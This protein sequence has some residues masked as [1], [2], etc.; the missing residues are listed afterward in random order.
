MNGYNSEQNLITP[1]L[2]QIGNSDWKYM[3]DDNFE[4]VRVYLDLA[5]ITD[6]QIYT[7]E[8]EKVKE[9]SD[10]QKSLDQISE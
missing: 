3:T 4:V 5:G 9:L 8:Y 1:Y 6:E 7:D 10:Y 2:L